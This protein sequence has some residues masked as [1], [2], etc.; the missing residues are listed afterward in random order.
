MSGLLNSRWAP[1]APT[2]VHRPQYTPR[3]QTSGSIRL[4]PPGSLLPPAEELSRFMKIVARLR[5]KLPFLAEGYRLATL[6]IGD[7]MSDNVA[8]AEIMFKIDFHEYYALLERAIVHLLA[9]FNIAV[10]SSRGSAHSSGNGVG[11]GVGNGH[12]VGV[13]R[14]HANVLEALREQTTPLSPVLG[15]GSV[16][17]QLQKAKDLRNRWKTADLTMEERERQGERKDVLRLA[18]FDFEGI[19]S[20]IFAG[21]EE[22]YVRAKDHVDKCVRP[23]DLPGQTN[24]EADWGFMVDAMDWEAV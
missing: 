8:H 17:L 23:D 1:G 21:L 19:L 14:Y 16:Y 18:D 11:N 5:W 9:V 13:H 3:P 22:A 20:G 2:S 4:T 10:T 15:S 7:D 12:S 24:T 6:E